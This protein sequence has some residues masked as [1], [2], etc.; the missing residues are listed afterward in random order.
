MQGVEKNRKLQ[1]FDFVRKGKIQDDCFQ[2]PGNRRWVWSKV[3][4]KYQGVRQLDTSLLL[5]NAPDLTR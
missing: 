4:R 3:S 2:Q 5:E 1:V